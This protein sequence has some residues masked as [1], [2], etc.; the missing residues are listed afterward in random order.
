MTAQIKEGLA[1][2]QSS[3]DQREARKLL[4]DVKKKCKSGKKLDL[5]KVKVVH[6]V[7]ARPRLL[8]Y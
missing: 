7:S 2:A 5:A 4:N 6:K 3:D 8:L 1:K